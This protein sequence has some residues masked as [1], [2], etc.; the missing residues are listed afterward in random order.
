MLRALEGDDVAAGELTLPDRVA[1]TVNAASEPDSS[2]GKQAAGGGGGSD[3]SSGAD[4][5]GKKQKKIFM[6]AYLGL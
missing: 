5:E 2:A 1:L 6:I 4:D 3:G